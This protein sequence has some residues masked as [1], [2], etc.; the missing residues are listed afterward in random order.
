[1]ND[2]QRQ[3]LIEQTKQTAKNTVKASDM[4]KQ[5]L[6]FNDNLN[7]DD[8]PGYPRNISIK[9]RLTK[10]NEILQ[11]CRHTKS[12]DQAYMAL[13]IDDNHYLFLCAGCV[14]QIMGFAHEKMVR[15]ALILTGNQGVNGKAVNTKNENES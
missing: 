9:M 13:L 7:V 2:E 5:G 6:E 10:D 12:P 1:M 11:L 8:P 4:F 15:D 14:A 3:K